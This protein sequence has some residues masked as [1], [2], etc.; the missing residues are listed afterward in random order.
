MASTVELALRYT[1]VYVHCRDRTDECDRGIIDTYTARPPPLR[2]RAIQEAFAS[3][4]DAVA[5]DTDAAGDYVRPPKNGA[6]A[7]L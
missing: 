6:A 3:P 1:T 4:I 2:S 7:D 5:G